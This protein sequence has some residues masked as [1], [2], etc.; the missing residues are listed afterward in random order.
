MSKFEDEFNEI[1][2]FLGDSTVASESAAA[3]DAATED[4]NP[5]EDVCPDDITL[6]SPA[7]EAFLFLTAL[8]EE[9]TPEEY[10]EILENSAVEMQ[11]YGLI[12]DASV[13]LEAQKNIVKLNKLA[14]FSKVQKRAAIRLAAQTNDQNY[15]L[16]RKGRDMMIAARDKIMTKYGA[17]AKQEAKKSIANSKK[18][19]MGMKSSGGKSIEKKID[20]TIAKL[21]NNART[22]NVIKS[23]D[24]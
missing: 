13:A 4:T 14:T 21:D 19:A 2:D 15:K 8:E 9:S 7:D 10:L 17:K 3:V 11:M 12:P 1:F 6:S 18:K 24:K 5:D 16:Y 22:N 23:S 20:R